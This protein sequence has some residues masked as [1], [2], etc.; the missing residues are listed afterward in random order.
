MNIPAL[1][2][3]SLTQKALAAL[4]AAVAKVVADRRQRGRPV[5]VWREGKAVWAFPAEA[6]VLRE[7]PTPYGVRAHEAKE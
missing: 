5:A 6:A 3:Q 1:P 2:R 7:A 4:Q